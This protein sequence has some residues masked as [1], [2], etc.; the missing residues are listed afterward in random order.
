MHATGKSCSHSIALSPHPDQLLACFQ[1]V[2][3]ILIVT[4]HEPHLLL[5]QKTLTSIP[6]GQALY[7]LCHRIIFVSMISLSFRMFLSTSNRNPNSNWLNQWYSP[8]IGVL[9]C[10]LGKYNSSTS[11]SW[12]EG[13]SRHCQWCQSRTPTLSISALCS[14]PWVGSSFRLAPLMVPD[15]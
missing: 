3:T 6:L 8:K 14:S 7:H 4:I 2:D 1:V 5:F 13:W 9:G 10:G 15:V 12:E 11:G